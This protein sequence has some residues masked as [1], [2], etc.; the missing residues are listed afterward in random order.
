MRGRGGGRGAPAPPPVNRVRLP[1]VQE[2][3]QK[4]V[5]Q[6]MPPE[7]YVWADYFEGRWRA[8]LKGEGSISRRWD[9]GS[10]LISAHLL[11]QD[12]WTAYLED[13]SLD[14]SS[15]PVD[16]IWKDP[17]AGVGNLVTPML[18]VTEEEAV[19]AEAVQANL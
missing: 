15:C 16:D 13:Q 4:R 9:D 3:T 8:C 6:C 11:L 19:A 17:Y 10:R 1:V 14:R 2:C 18:A 5:K 12:I 7:S